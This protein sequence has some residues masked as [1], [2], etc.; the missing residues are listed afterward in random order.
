MKKFSQ[1]TEEHPEF[2]HGWGQP[3]HQYGMVSV[4]GHGH[5]KGYKISHYD[6][7]SQKT[8][9][10]RDGHTTTGVSGH[11]ITGATIYHYRNGEHGVKVHNRDHHGGSYVSHSELPRFATKKE[12]VAH[13]IKAG[14]KE[15]KYAEKM[16]RGLHSWA[17]A[18][19]VSP[20]DGKRSQAGEHKTAAFHKLK[21]ANAGSLNGGNNHRY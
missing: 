19:K 10:Q 9:M 16:D 14:R 17:K 8:E 3:K 2:G 13:A 4:K 5:R 12:A 20:G 6:E 21:A 1:I 11:D 18:N 7:G 15:K